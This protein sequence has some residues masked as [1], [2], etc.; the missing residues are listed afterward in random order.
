MANIILDTAAVFV[1]LFLGWRGARRGL[2]LSLCGLLAIVVA[3]AGAHYISGQFA[4]P[5]SKLLE[6]SIEY[7]IDKSL[8][9]KIEEDPVS[10]QPAAAETP[11][12]TGSA[13]PAESSSPAPS[14]GS[15]E[16]EDTVTPDTLSLNQVLSVLSGA[17]FFRSLTESLTDKVK[18]SLLTAA[19]SA[20]EAI[21]SYWALQLAEG[22]L[23]VLSFA[24]ILLLWFLLSHALDLAC[25]LPG[26]HTLNTAGGLIIGLVKG[27]L[28]LM[29][30]GL[31][32][33]TWTV[34]PSSALEK[35]VV[36]KYFVGADF[37]SA[38]VQTTPA[39]TETPQYSQ[40]VG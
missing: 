32:L 2:V 29:I 5:V 6:P 38:A 26:L 14:S 20:A 18:E 21:A 24:V 27:V 3:F 7:S 35:T 34:V 13:D 36:L 23:F 22:L 10:F 33:R 11:A 30:V 1:L 8:K 37:L 17:K 12:P 19:S 15:G 28:I 9:S 31:V 40:F 4:E 16:E 25:R 39:V